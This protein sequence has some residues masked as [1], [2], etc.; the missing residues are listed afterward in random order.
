M[1]FKAMN[2]S[3]DIFIKRKAIVKTYKIKGTIGEVNNPKAFVIH[4]SLTV[5]PSKNIVSGIV[6]IR[7]EI[8][9][10]CIKLNVVGK[11]E[12]SN[13]YTNNNVVHLFGEY[14]VSLP[15][16]TIGCYLEKFTACL[17]VDNNW[18]GIG[19]FISGAKNENNI[20]VKSI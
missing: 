9:K 7:Q 13:Y 17:E 10:Q 3:N 6:K 15:P 5:S 16:L 1:F 18:N 20:P 12:S 14:L 4:F 11:I 8:N 19:S 2:T